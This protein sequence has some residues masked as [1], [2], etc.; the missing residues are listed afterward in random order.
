V[1]LLRAL[2]AG[3]AGTTLGYGASMTLPRDASHSAGWAPLVAIS[4]VMFIVALDATMLNVAIPDI[5][6]DLGTT[7]SAVQSAVAL[8]SL[9]M[10]ALMVG[11]G[12]VG[13][14]LGP[15]RVYRAALVIFG[16]GTLMAAL[17]PNVTILILGWSLLEGIGAAALIPISLSMTSTSYSG[18]RRALAFGVLGG[19]QAIAAAMGPIIGGFLATNLSWRYAFGLEVVVVVIVLAM[20]RWLADRPPQR[21]QRLDFVGVALWGIGLVAIVGSVLLA[22]WYGW[23]DAKRPLVIGG[24]EI[25]LGGIAPTPLLML[26]G[27][28]VL[29][30]FV[31]W[32][33]RRVEQ[34]LDP[35]FR[36]AT[37]R[38]TDFR[39]G[40]ATDAL[41]S[42]LIA[43]L[44]FTI[45]VFLQSGLGY[46]A[47]DAGVALLPMSVAIFF[48]SLG[49]TRVVHLVRPK[50][51]VQVSAIT[52]GIGVVAYASVLGPTMTT[53]DSI[54][55]L[56]LIGGGIGGLLS[57][58]TNLTLARV[59]DDEKGSATGVYNT[60]KELG[61]S[62]GTALIGSVLLASFYTSF[63][64]T[65][66]R[67]AAVDLHPD[68]ARRLAIAL[69]DAQARFDQ[70][71]FE[72]I[73]VAE[74]PPAAAAQVDRIVQQ[75][76]VD[77][78]RRA[79]E[80]AFVVVVLI[81]AASTFLRGRR[82]A[83]VDPPVP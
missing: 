48:A 39:P 1:A 47:L 9:T 40:T 76:W 79:L 81:F 5:V 68:E 34:G 32:S 14:L 83:T 29:V 44:L 33:R 67:V 23:W 69:E 55:P 2:E 27:I 36:F 18:P 64:D 53:I 70:A 43:G 31:H 51:I 73:V 25:G 49:L 72:R 75:S 61:T 57:Q 16:S 12:R 24:T 3:T 22:G 54:V 38:V 45:P 52:L 4:M 60:A 77:A 62:L 19:F 7:T 80:T 46:T 30:A 26:A 11:A 20:S 56:L 21:D 6:K 65:T 28:L 78:M 17:A 58:L 50:R 63:V 59:P 8:Y 10:A 71:T 37:L 42:L 74:M 15:K 41:E 82:S 13:D 35:L 66:V